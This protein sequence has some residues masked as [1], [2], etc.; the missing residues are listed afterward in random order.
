MY[1]ILQ[2]LKDFL[3]RVGNDFEAAAALLGDGTS[4]A[5]LWGEWEHMSALYELDAIMEYD[6]SWFSLEAAE[7]WFKL[8]TN[9]IQARRSHE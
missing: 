4:A 7:A 1:R 5:Q 3:P 2:S 8:K 9:E 6:L